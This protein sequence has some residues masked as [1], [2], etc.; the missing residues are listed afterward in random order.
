VQAPLKFH[1]VATV[2]EVR[3]LED[4]GVDYI[5]FHVDEDAV[6][7]IDDAPFWADDR[8]LML[9]QLEELLDAVDRARPFVECS[10]DIAEETIQL[11]LS[12]GVNLF[13]VNTYLY[14]DDL[15][16][17]G[18]EQK[19][20]EIIYGNQYVVPGDDPR[21]L[22]T[23]DKKWPCLF[24]I[25]L[26]IFPSEKDAWQLLSNPSVEVEKDIV[27]LKDLELLAREIPLFLALNYTKDNYR[28]VSDRLSALPKKGF[29]ITLSPTKYGSFHTYEF[30]EL[31]QTIQ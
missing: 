14:L 23:I 26:Q 24:A 10:P 31:L 28:I 4:A 18:Q 11:M 21:F 5:G 16:L 30:E 12:K 2:E 15:W 29:S 13:Q 19:G 6:L 1:R 7:G 3:R 25:D 22:S 17:A 20:I 8:Y 27:I 9:E